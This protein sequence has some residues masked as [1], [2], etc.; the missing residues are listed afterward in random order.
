MRTWW[1]GGT[2]SLP[3]QSE[4]N[5]ILWA[6]CISPVRSNIKSQHFLSRYPV[7]VNAFSAS[8]ETFCFSFTTPT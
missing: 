5:L 3:I 2:F 6:G 4:R 8:S 1:R 7:R